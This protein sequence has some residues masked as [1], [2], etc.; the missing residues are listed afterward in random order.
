MNALIMESYSKEFFLYCFFCKSFILYFLLHTLS[1]LAFSHPH[2]SLARFVKDNIVDNTVLLSK[3][4]SSD[5]AKLICIIV[6]KV[7]KYFSSYFCI[8]LFVCLFSFSFEVSF[9]SVRFAGE[10][11]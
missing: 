6:S 3:H 1:F 8:L 11:M 7:M 10:R 2:I 4:S 5:Y 9:L